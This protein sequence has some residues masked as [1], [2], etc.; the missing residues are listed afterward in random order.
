MKFDLESVPEIRP[1]SIPR[2]AP[3]IPNEK[4]ELT[5]EMLEYIWRI[6]DSYCK[7]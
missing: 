6:G 4:T 2:A 3:I 1:S 7:P 5:L